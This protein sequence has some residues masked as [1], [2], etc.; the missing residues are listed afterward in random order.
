MKIYG[1]IKE[2]T[3]SDFSKSFIDYKYHQEV[4]NKEEI[5]YYL[6]SGY[7]IAAT[8]HVIKSLFD[9][10]IIAGV[11]YYTDG[12]W[13]WPNYL[14]YYLENY[15]IEIPQDFQYHIFKNINKK[16]SPSVAQKGTHFLIKNKVL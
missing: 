15:D 2:H 3:E 6:K 13:I 14:Y 4:D 10:E 16:I 5:L 11:S 1:F 12:K 8:M 9:N 7:L